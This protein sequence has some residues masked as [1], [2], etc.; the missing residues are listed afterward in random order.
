MEARR[1]RTPCRRGSVAERKVHRRVSCG[2]CAVCRNRRKCESTCSLLDINILIAGLKQVHAKLEVMSPA[3][4]GNVIDDVVMVVPAMLRQISIGMDGCVA[5][6][7]S[8]RRS[9]V[10]CTGNAWIVESAG[11]FGKCKI[12]ILTGAWLIK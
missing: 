1:R 5:R 12:H 9:A 10:D 6:N 8:L 3:R 2:Q 11:D 7:R 4:P